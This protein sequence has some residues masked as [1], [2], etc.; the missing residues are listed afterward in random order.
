M[1]FAVQKQREP[2]VAATIRSGSPWRKDWENRGFPG[3]PFL[4]GMHFVSPECEAIIT[5]L[6][7]ANY[8]RQMGLQL[9]FIRI[10]EKAEAEEN[11]AANAKC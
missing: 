8:M 4:T 6:Q 10:L 3:V 9:R 11:V 1:F 5:I 2:S 7:D